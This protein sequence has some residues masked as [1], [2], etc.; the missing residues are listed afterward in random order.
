MVAIIATPNNAGKDSLNGHYEMMGIISDIP[1]KT[2]NDGFPIEILNS[3][4]YTTG[5]RTVGCYYSAYH[6]F[7]S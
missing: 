3:I 5:R 4:E 2:F 6:P 7:F 1:F